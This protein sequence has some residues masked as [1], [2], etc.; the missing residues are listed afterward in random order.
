MESFE[1]LF[2]ENPEFG[3]KLFRLLEVYGQRE[4]FVSRELLFSART[5]EIKTPS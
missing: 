4:Q 5:P 1:E 2:P 3:R